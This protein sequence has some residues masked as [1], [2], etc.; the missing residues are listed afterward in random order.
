VGVARAV[1][2]SPGRALYRGWCGLV[3]VTGIGRD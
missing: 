1:S 2:T 3:N